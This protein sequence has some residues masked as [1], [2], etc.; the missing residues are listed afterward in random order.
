M[1]KVIQTVQRTQGSTEKRYDVDRD[2]V[3]LGITKGLVDRDLEFH[4]NLEGMKEKI[5]LGN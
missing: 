4:R 5:V 2:R 1:A 3:S